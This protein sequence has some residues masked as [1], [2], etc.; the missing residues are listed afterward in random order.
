M[1]NFS[2]LKPEID[3]G[4][5]LKLKWHPLSKVIPLSRLLSDVW[6]FHIFKVYCNLSLSHSCDISSCFIYFKS[7]EKISILNQTAVKYSIKA[8]YSMKIEFCF[9][10]FFSFPSRTDEQSQI[11]KR[12]PKNLTKFRNLNF[13]AKTIPFFW[14]F[15]LF[16]WFQKGQS[17]R[18]YWPP[19]W[20]TRVSL[21]SAWVCCGEVC[22]VANGSCVKFFTYLLV[23][24]G[25]F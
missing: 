24:I 3:Q 25:D 9:P 11:Q 1:Y 7:L 10:V 14:P 6:N 21:Q 12:I 13:S 2:I 22:W 4:F 5:I 17:A 16:D 8:K 19:Y 18:S 20:K 23:I 15:Q